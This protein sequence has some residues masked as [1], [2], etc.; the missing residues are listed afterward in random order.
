MKQSAYN[1]L[2]VLNSNRWHVFTSL[3]FALSGS[4]RPLMVINYWSFYFLF[5]FL[6]SVCIEY[7]FGWLNETRTANQTYSVFAKAFNKQQQT[8][9]H[10]LFEIKS[11]SKGVQF[12]CFQNYL[13]SSRYFLHE[14]ISIFTT[15][16]V[17]DNIFR[18][19]L[20]FFH[21]QP[22]PHFK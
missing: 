10:E 1:A 12:L 11:H 2:N 3:S 17:S 20:V 22:Q 7:R 19:D 15:N 21:V 18:L 8:E 9:R 5:H 4:F 14:I 6:F 13:N 16:N